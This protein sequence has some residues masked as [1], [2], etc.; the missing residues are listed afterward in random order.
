MAYFCFQLNERPPSFCRL[1]S[2]ITD[3]SV[4]NKHLYSLLVVVFFDCFSLFSFYTKKCFKFFST[5]THCI[6]SDILCIVCFEN[7][8]CS[9][10]IETN[11]FSHN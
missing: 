10:V 9:V 7:K 6:A 3:R 4:T 2:L 5:C 8:E 1:A 11:L